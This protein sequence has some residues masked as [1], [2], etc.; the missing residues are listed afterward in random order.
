MSLP[1]GFQ[2]LN[3]T[4]FTGAQQHLTIV[5]LGQLALSA[6]ALADLLTQTVTLIAQMLAVD[7]VSIVVL[8]ACDD[9]H[10][11]KEILPVDVDG[12]LNKSEPAAKIRETI[13]QAPEKHFVAIA[14]LLIVLSKMGWVLY[15]TFSVA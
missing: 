14:S 6:I 3:Q 13:Y 10:F 9:D 11:I 15:Q 7:Y 1:T 8:S 5:R 12:Y 2:N 4:I